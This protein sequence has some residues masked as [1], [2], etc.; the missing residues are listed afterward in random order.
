MPATRVLP[1]E[2]ATALLEP[3][4]VAHVMWVPL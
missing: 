2:E 4:L 1:T 3:D